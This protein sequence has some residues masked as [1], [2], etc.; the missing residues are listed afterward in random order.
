MRV[1]KKTL[2]LTVVIEAETPEDA[3]Y[4]ALDRFRHDLGQYECLAMTEVTSVK[5]LPPD[6]RPHDVA[7][8]G[9]ETT[10]GERLEP[11]GLH[12]LAQSLEDA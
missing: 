12:A 11:Q 5:D 1:F 10:L 9:D 4:W 8:N 3:Q 2:E 7:D 6:Y